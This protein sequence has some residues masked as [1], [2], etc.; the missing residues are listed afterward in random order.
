MES[1]ELSVEAGTS[2]PPVDPMEELEDEMFHGPA[3]MTPCTVL[4]FKKMLLI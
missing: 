2:L 3:M 4:L 1:Y